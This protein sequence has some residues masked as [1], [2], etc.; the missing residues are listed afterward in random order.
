MINWLQRSSYADLTEAEAS[1]VRAGRERELLDE[2]ILL[3]AAWTGFPL[4]PRSERSD[5][6]ERKEQQ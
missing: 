4:F 6:H 1:V 2:L 3:S 5:E